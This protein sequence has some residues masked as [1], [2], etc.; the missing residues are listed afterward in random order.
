M[1]RHACSA[2]GYKRT[3]TVFC[4]PLAF[5]LMSSILSEYNRSG[6]HFPLAQAPKEERIFIPCMNDRGFQSRPSVI[7]NFAPGD[8][9]PDLDRFVCAGG[10]KISAV[11]RP[12]DC[13][14][15]NI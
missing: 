10:S 5:L 4:M 2:V 1:S 12:G 6:K 7:H 11:E 13:V 3:W 9:V 14:Y 8:S 15:L